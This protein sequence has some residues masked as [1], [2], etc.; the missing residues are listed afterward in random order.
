[1]DLEEK[2]VILEFC[3]VVFSVEERTS[4]KQTKMIEGG[5]EDHSID[6]TM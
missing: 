6:L 5:D 4:Q 3:F 2:L 1:M